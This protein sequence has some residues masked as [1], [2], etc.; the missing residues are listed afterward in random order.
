MIRGSVLFIIFFLPLVFINGLQMLSLIVYP[1]SQNIFRA[2]NISFAS[3]VWSSMVF[4]MEKVNGI[5]I[6]VVGDKIPKG[7][8]AVVDINHQNVSDIPLMMK[9]AL[10]TGRLGNLKFFAKDV[11]KYIPGPGWGCAFIDTIFV[12]RNWLSDKRTVDQTF[13]KFKDRKIPFWIVTFLEGTRLTPEKLA[14]SQNF[15]RRRNMTVTKYVMAPKTKGFIASV[16]SLRKQLDAVYNLTIHYP[17][18][19]PT[20]WDLLNG[21]LRRVSIHVKRTPIEE[22]PHEVSEL[23]NWV[24]DRYIEKDM[25][26]SKLNDANSD[27]KTYNSLLSKL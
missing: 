6:S 2:I 3:M 8:N 13:Q 26:L 17:D 11:V 21:S 22:L 24:F 18:G 20:L 12:K 16:S 1:F 27:S 4:L 15:M 19:V 5:H 7:E 25:L 10:P 9:V 14:R 23:E